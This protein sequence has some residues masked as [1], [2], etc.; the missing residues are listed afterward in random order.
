[1]KLSK[2]DDVKNE[3]N[4]IRECKNDKHI[5]RD[6]KFGITWCIRCGRLFIKPCGKSI[7]EEDRLRFECL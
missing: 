3:K 1:M 5:R 2:L 7:T 4:N 6:N